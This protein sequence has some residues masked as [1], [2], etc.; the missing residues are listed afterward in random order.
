MESMS[1]LLFPCHHLVA[2]ISPLVEADP[3]EA[4]FAT[5]GDL[6]TKGSIWVGPTRLKYVPRKDNCVL[7]GE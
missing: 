2:I 3:D 6:R 5:Q 4:L 1:A 7:R